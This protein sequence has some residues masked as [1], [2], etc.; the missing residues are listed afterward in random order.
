MS[1]REAREAAAAFACMYVAGIDVAEV[2]RVYPDRHDAERIYE[3]LRTAAHELG[4]RDPRARTKVRVV[5]V[6]ASPLV[7][8]LLAVSWIAWRMKGMM[9]HLRRIVGGGSGG[10]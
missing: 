4:W 10:Q 6:A 8:P 5:A 2:L 7:I 3:E 9:I 1:Q